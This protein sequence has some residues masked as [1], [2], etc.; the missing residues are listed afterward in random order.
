[1]T[2]RRRRRAGRARLPRRFSECWPSR[3]SSHG[4]PQREVEAFCEARVVRLPA[5]DAA[6]RKSPEAWQK[7][8]DE[9]RKDVLDK[10]VFRG[11]A[12]NWR[13][14]RGKVEWL[15]TIEGGDGYTI[16]KLRYEALPGLW[17]PG[18]LYEPAKLDGKVP[19]FLN[20]NGHDGNGKAADYK[21]IRC[22]NHGQARASS[23]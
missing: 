14:C 8:A 4:T 23:R 19:V 10:V 20:V 11:E 5:E 13:D 18:L 22:I 7:Y 21:Q 1:M 9:L 6:E 12:A 15:D 16:K 3:S 17:I 2:C